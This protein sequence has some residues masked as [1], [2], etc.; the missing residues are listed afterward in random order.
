MRSILTFG[1]AALALAITSAPALA[2]GAAQS[3]EAT[4]PATEASPSAS[5][6]SGADASAT[7]ATLAVGA[8]VKDKTGASIGQVT[9]VK[10]DDTGKQVATIKMGADSFAVETDKLA[11]A[12]GSA[13]INATQAE[14]K[15][16]LAK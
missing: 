12:D 10:P 8:T 3:D 16:M 11:I 13:T 4:A 1:A 15:A 5:S 6:P 14:L 7:A 2:Q 9:A